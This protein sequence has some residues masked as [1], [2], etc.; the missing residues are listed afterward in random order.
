MGT[1]PLVQ[2]LR[3]QTPSAGGLGSIPDQEIRLHILQPEKDLTCR[4]EDLVQPN[5]TS[6]WVIAKKFG[7]VH[8]FICREMCPK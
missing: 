4:S 8:M 2:W 1:S 5:K 7:M 6:A 3:F